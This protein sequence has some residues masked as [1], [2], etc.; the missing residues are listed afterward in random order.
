MRNE[1]LEMQLD[2]PLVVGFDGSGRA[3]NAVVWAARE[4][5][6][7][8]LP[9]RLVHATPYPAA[10]PPAE[11]GGPE[12]PDPVLDRG[13]R[14]ARTYLPD[15]LVSGVCVP[16]H[17]AGV[18][19]DQSLG[20]TLVVVGQRSQ[21]GPVSS[22]VGSTSLVLAD[23]AACPVVVA[24]GATDAQRAALP[25]VVS[26]CGGTTSRAVLDF[27]AHAARLRGV[28]LSIVSAW[29]LPP[30]REWS[31]AAGGFDSVAEW[32]RATATSA[33]RAAR[34]TEQDVHESC[35]T[36]VTSTQVERA[37]PADALVHSSRRAG[38]VVVGSARP[39]GLG[40]VGATVLGLA[41]CPVAVVPEA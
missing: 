39:T 14:V 33:A 7:R 12:E 27:A 19:A 29:S 23:R 10:G 2:N 8:G 31:G 1:R 26:A 32:V 6:R 22:A 18:L 24:R 9:L 3:R 4:A 35:P 15:D 41:A 13:L 16:G 20:A 34:A 37:D 5:A 30:S 11:V 25:V 21:D 36:L 38:L 28:P 17:A 40:R